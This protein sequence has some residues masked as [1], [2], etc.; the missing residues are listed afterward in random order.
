MPGSPRWLGDRR[1]SPRAGRPVRAGRPPDQWADRVL[2]EHGVTAREGTCRRGDLVRSRCAS[3]PMGAPVT[4]VEAT[5]E[6]LLADG[7][8][9]PVPAPARSAARRLQGASGRSF[10]GGLAEPLYTTPAVLDLHERL[11]RTVRHNPGA[12]SL[13]SYR[14]GERLAALDALGVLASRRDGP[15]GAIAPGRAAAASFESVTGIETAAVAGWAGSGAGAGA[16]AVVV[17]AEAHRLG[18]WELASVVE[19]CVATGGRVVLFAPTAA[20]ENEFVTASILA[21]HLVSFSPEAW[22]RERSTVRGGGVVAEGHGFS[23]KEVI[24]VPDGAAARDALL[25]TWIERR[26]SAGGALLVASDDAVVLA[27]RESV[28]A[29]GGRPDDVVEARRLAGRLAGRIVAGSPASSVEPQIVVLGPLPSGLGDVPAAGCVH[30]AI[31][32][33]Q[34]SGTERL[35]RAA[36]VARPRHLVSE[37][38]SVRSSPSDRS[39]W[40]AGATAIETFRRRW[41]IDDPEHAFGDRS[42]VLARGVG[43]AGDLAETKLKVRAA[44]RALDLATP[45]RARR[46]REVPDRSRAVTLGR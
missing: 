31:V 7:R 5:V 45:A 8:V 11:E 22:S 18:P 39:A 26:A 13:L 35:G 43:A 46:T 28:R 3:L 17:V 10:P 9:I 42:A 14:P 32:P 12:I 37:L 29:A 19:S 2:G 23:G 44:V 1:P 16:G 20:L 30:V 6:A 24:V 34:A 15:V 25:S 38:G 4:E 33:F 36:E 21:P 40:R 27:L 41:S